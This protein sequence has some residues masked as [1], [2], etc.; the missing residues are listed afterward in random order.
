VTAAPVPPPSTSSPSSPRASARPVAIV[1]GASRGIGAAIALELA[2]AGHDV[3]LLA[4]SV[5]DL[6]RSAAAVRAVGGQALVLPTDA[7]DAAAVAAAV[8]AV[9]QAFGR[10]DVVVAN[11]G[12]YRRA[13]ATAVT[14]G[15]IE[16]ALRD[17][18][19]SAFHLLDACVPLLR[20][21][22]RGH[23]VI[24]NSFDAKKG[25]PLDAA[26]AAAKAALASFGASLRQDLRQDGVHVCSVFPGRVDTAMV[27][28]LDVP[29]IS[30][31]IPAERV[32]RAVLRGMRWRRAEVLVP[33][34]IR[35]LWWLDVLSPR[36]GDWLVRVLRLDGRE[37]VP[38]A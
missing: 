17:N 36:L 23:V 24:L 1:T 38:R 20:T 34:H 29:A 31:K 8:R 18:F 6:E 14:R 15:D 19:W 4:R 11:A 3:A 32:A 22:R 27:G 13:P 37:R 26:Y 28:Q 33:W 12:V 21:Q 25:L 5:P 35:S 7:T 2:R 9:Q 30:A 10:V 16:L